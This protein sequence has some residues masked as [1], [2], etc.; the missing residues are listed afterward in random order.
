MRSLA[1]SDYKRTPSLNYLPTSVTFK[2]SLRRIINTLSG[3]T[4]SVNGI[5]VDAI[6]ATQEA[7]E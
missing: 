6:S 2:P 1:W 7:T 3:E 4:A 5:A